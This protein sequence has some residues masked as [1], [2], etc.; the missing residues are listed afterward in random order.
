[1]YGVQTNPWRTATDA[2]SVREWTHPVMKW[3]TPVGNRGGRS[4]S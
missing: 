4:S 2:A 1:M 3:L